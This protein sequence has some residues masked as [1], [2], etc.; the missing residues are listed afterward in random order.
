VIERTADRPWI[1]VLRAGAAALALFGF[2]EAQATTPEVPP[3]APGTV[4]VWYRHTEGC[5]DGTSFVGLLERLHRSVSLAGV[6][7]HVDFVV[8]LAFSP[9]QSS[10]RLERQSKEGTVAIREVTA[11]TCQ[12]VA[13]VLAL[14]LDLAL[15]PEPEPLAAEPSVGAPEAATE[16]GWQS[17]LGAQA[18]ITAGLAGTLL[19]GA[20]LFFD[21]RPAVSGWS[22]RMSLRGALGERDAAVDLLVGLATARLEGCWSR[23]FG[24]VNAGPCLGLDLGLV[25]AEGSGNTGRSDAGV[26]SSAG[27]SARAGWQLGESFTL[28]AQAGLLAPFVRYRFSAVEGGDVSTSATFG[29]DAAV[30]CSFRL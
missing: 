17:R 13:E 8:T 12:E 15:Q 7:D 29:F 23:S 14:S 30:G 6:G 2:R 5:L 21:L 25:F 9:Q 16:P 11:S 10:G 4:R 1:V 27:V 18:A 24:S 19:P 3:G 28:E 22:G 20:A 26:W